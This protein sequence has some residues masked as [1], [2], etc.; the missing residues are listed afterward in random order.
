M[1][2]S[3]ADS[4][5]I[6]PDGTDQLKLEHLVQH[7]RAFEPRSATETI[8]KGDIVLK[9]EALGAEKLE[10][11]CK[12]VGLKRRGSSFRK[13][14]SIGEAAA[15]LWP[16]RDRL[17][18]KWTTIYL[19]SQLPPYQLAIVAT[20]KRFGPTMTERDLHSILPQPQGPRRTPFSRD[21]YIDVTTAH[22]LGS[23]FSRLDQLKAEFG[24]DY[25]CRKDLKKVNFRHKPIAK[26][27]PD[28]VQH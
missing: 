9:A 20:D 14:R 25:R 26:E 24:I 19:L 16:L 4:L 12:T 17:P 27:L 21:V 22:D 7:Y 6:V 11:F 13:Y 3:I 5:V 10:A 1:T 28:N 23:L 15:E 18:A 8:I 2:N